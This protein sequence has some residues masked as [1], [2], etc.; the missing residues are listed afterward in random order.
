M[1]S[2]RY[3]KLKMLRFFGA[4]LL[5]WQGIFW[6]NLLGLNTHPVLAETPDSNKPAQCESVDC[7]RGDLDPNTPH[8]ISPRNSFILSDRPLLRWYQVEGATRYL[9]KVQGPSFSWEKQTSEPFVTYDGPELV[10]GEEYLVV[11]STHDGEQE[12]KSTFS[13]VTAETEQE[14]EMAIA[15]VGEELSPSEKMTEIVKIYEEELL[16]NDAIDV[17]E[18]YL[19]EFGATETV[20]DQLVRLYNEVGLHQKV[21]FYQEQRTILNNAP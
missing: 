19:E 13:R 4:P 12:D 5:L 18:A 3:Q 2:Q 15:A 7:P 6:A 16:F 14:I 10:P 21:K 17:V 9:V 1:G 8:I 11:V 20:Y